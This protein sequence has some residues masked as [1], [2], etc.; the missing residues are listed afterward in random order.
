MVLCPHRLPEELGAHLAYGIFALYA[1]KIAAAVRLTLPQ[2]NEQ[3]HH[4]PK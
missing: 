4:L 1:Q 3:L 2:V